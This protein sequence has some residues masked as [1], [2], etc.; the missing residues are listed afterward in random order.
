MDSVAEQHHDPKAEILHTPR[1]GKAS[2]VETTPNRQQNA[3][4]PFDS[5]MRQP[6]PPG[7]PVKRVLV[8]QASPQPLEASRT[9]APAA[10][11]A[12]WLTPARIVAFLVPHPREIKT[13]QDQ[14]SGGER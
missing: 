5:D 13:G 11:P 10:Q 9:K 1:R 12:A 6:I 14:A 7:Q 2:Q 4:S 8:E 3:D